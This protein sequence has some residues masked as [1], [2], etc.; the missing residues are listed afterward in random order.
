[1]LCHQSKANK[2]ETEEKSSC[3]YLPVRE[4]LQSEELGMYVS[5]GILALRKE[6]NAWRRAAYLSDIST[7]R[8]AVAALARSCTEG[9]LSPEQLSEVVED[10]LGV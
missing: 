9:A 6:G 7:D 1:M 4:N 8:E 2:A 10:F 3:V 5:Y